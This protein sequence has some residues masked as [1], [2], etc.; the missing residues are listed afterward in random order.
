[1]GPFL[2]AG[3]ARDEPTILAVGPSCAAR[4]VE[5][6]EGRD[7]LI[8][9]PDTEELRRPA[10]RLQTLQRTIGVHLAAG[11]ERI[12]L[13]SA[14]PTDPD[15]A[16]ALAWQPWA[17]FEA[18]LDIA[19]ADL[20]VWQLCLYDQRTAGPLA[21]ADV[22][23][24]HTHLAT[25][26]D[27]H[28]EVVDR[29]DPVA[30]LGSLLLLDEPASGPGEPV[31]ELHDPS[32]GAARHA[33]QEL[34]GEVG[35]AADDREGLVSAVSEIVT[36]ARLHGQP[37][38]E[39]C[40]WTSPGEVIVSVTDHGVGPTDPAV[41]LA[42]VARGAGEGGYGLWIAHQVC[43][44]VTLHRSRGAFTVRMVARTRDRG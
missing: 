43:R 26:R 7:D 20:P 4:L 33:V 25:V 29:P 15:E 18:Y 3:L 2:A 31:A 8:V 14:L 1:M 22:E 37:P 27:G 36:N 12:R 19:F 30:V 13:V 41:G 32:P 6:T 17:R 35:L 44:S 10:V 38:V 21:L 23:R 28:Q 5:A 42:P 9:L 11:A 24:C 40:A 16:P 34:A 39:V